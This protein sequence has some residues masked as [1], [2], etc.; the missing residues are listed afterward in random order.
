[1][2]NIEFDKITMCKQIE[3]VK[4]ENFNLNIHNWIIEN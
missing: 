4:L 2:Y 1:M 3:G